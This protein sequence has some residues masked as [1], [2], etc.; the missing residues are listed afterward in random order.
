MRLI[1]NVGRS[2]DQGVATSQGKE[3]PAYA[4]ATGAIELAA[5]DARQLGVLDGDAVRVRSAH[6]ESTVKCRLRGTGDL[7]RGMGFMAFG[8][9]ASR[10][11]GGE[12]HATGM[13]DSKGL[14]VEVE[15][16][17]EG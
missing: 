6:G 12:T 5:E 17:R 15:R 3:T 10:L 9:P 4:A 16:D 2:S 14:P 8:P 11:M 1:L 7:P 13:P